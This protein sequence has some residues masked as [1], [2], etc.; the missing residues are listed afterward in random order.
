M[1]LKAVAVNQLAALGVV[2]AAV[3]AE[4]LGRLF[5]PTDTPAASE[6]VAVKYAAALQNKDAAALA[7]L[8]APQIVFLDTAVNF[9]PP[10][11]LLGRYTSIFR[12]P[13]DLKFANL[14]Y[15]V[16]RGWAAVIWTAASQSMNAS[17]GGVTMLEIR[18]GEIARE[19]LYY[20]SSYMPF[21]A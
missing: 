10:Q 16:G 21:Q 5:T 2:V 12:A 8:S 20:N 9:M 11:T 17:G 6:A 3:Q 7:A 14:K 13:A 1:R 15:A 19:T 4:A 18:D